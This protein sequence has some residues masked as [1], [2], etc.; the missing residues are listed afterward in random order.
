MN[1]GQRFPEARGFAHVPIPYGD[2]EQILEMVRRTSE[3]AQ[4]LANL[5]LVNNIPLAFLAHNRLGYS[6]AFAQY[7]VSIGKSVNVCTG[8]EDEIN[9]AL[10][11]IQTNNHSGAVLDVLTAWYAADLGVFPALEKQL[12]TLAIPATEFSCL[13]SIL[14]NFMG[15]EGEEV[16]GL[17]YRDGEFSR[18]V[19]TPEESTVRR[20][21]VESRIETIKETCTIEPV[22]IPDNLTEAGEQLM[23]LPFSDAVSPAVIAGQDRLLLCEDMVMRQ[24]ASS[25]FGT[26]SVWIQVVLW[27]ALQNGT[28]T[29]DQ[30]SDA[31]VRLAQIRHGFMPVSAYV[32]LSVFM[33]DN[34]DDLLQFQALCDYLGSGKVEPASYTK[35]VSQFIN[36][37]WISYL[38][39]DNKVSTATQIVLHSL[40]IRNSEHQAQH[41]PR[42]AATLNQRPRDYFV[43]WCQE[44][45][46]AVDKED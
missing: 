45:G 2:F 7:L 36:T 4:N 22:V 41:V 37:L 44:N 20:E 14:N 28:M 12:G 24:L 19:I 18:H 31:L 8:S 35:L 38:T 40:F 15:G 29:L 3:E 5:Y 25:V 1:F 34:S 39:D 43:K 23:E 46:V 33:R 32:L 30:Y 16:M 42:L 6:I 17:S 9:D 11:L 13:Q 10:G 27:S 21:L 26:K